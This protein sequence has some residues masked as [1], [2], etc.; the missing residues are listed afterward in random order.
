MSAPWMKTRVQVS[1]QVLDFVR[2]RAP[3]PRKALRAGIRGLAEDLGDIKRLEG[4]LTGYAR[5]RVQ[6]FRVVFS[7]TVKEGGRVIECVFAEE[8]SVVYEIFA[9]IYA[10]KVTDGQPPTSP[11]LRVAPRRKAR[12]G[13]H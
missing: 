5:L 2:A 3:E 8:R 7:E 4:K 12:K 9:K 6:H 10:S 1:D 11:P 13:D